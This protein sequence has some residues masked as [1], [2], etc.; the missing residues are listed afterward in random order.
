MASLTTS[1]LLSPEDLEDVEPMAGLANLMDVMLVFACGLI[2]ALIAHYNVNLSQSPESVNMQELE[3]QLE[4]AEQGAADN[5][6]TYR[7]LG[8]VYQDE[9]TGKLYV[10]VPDGDDEGGS[11]SAVD[12]G[13]EASS[14]AAES[15]EGSEGTESEG[16]K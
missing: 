6:D 8:M 2:L 15:A 13:G 7:Q 14:G 3:G 9:Q 4:Y 1:K 12:A 16:G 10:V 5:G 11:G